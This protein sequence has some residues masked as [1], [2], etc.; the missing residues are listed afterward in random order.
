MQLIQGITDFDDYVEWGNEETSFP[1]AII[2]SEKST[3]THADFFC[4]WGNVFFFR[5]NKK[6]KILTWL[7]DDFD[8]KKNFRVYNYPDVCFLLIPGHVFSFSP[9][10]L[11]LEEVFS[12]QWKKQSNINIRYFW[13]FLLFQSDDEAVIL[14]PDGSLFRKISVSPWEDLKNLEW[15]FIISEWSQ[16]GSLMRYIWKDQQ[17]S[18]DF[19]FMKERFVEMYRK[20]WWNSIEV[21]ESPFKKGGV[22][23][24]LTDENG[25]YI[26]EY[27]A[28]DSE[29]GF[30]L[31]PIFSEQRARYYLAHKNDSYKVWKYTLLDF[32]NRLQL[33]DGA[34]AYDVQEMGRVGDNYFWDING[35]LYIRTHHVEWTGWI[36]TLVK[37]DL[38]NYNNYR[39]E[40]GQLTAKLVTYG[41]VVSK[42]TGGKRYRFSSSERKFERTLF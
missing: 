21:I 23:L 5:D 12:Q 35:E 20:I 40:Y 19:S 41:G 39:L 32:D 9:D 17:G 28:W 27:D 37:A 7:G 10:N 22:I 29:I 1:E 8:M 26:A 36:G 24:M 6:G 3:I 33:L 14:N 15:D 25:K 42:A 18:F 11:V 2:D 31:N 34:N 16:W 30:F 38:W 4:V 13:D